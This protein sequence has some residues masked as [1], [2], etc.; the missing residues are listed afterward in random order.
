M[1]E[2]LLVL[3]N[4]IGKARSAAEFIKGK[5]TAVRRRR[6]SQDFSML[7]SCRTDER[8]E[9]ELP[10]GNSISLYLR[11]LKDDILLSADIPYRPLISQLR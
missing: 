3:E 1:Y 11:V 4:V 8:K 9:V 7:V 10:Q 6:D 5:G 2:Q